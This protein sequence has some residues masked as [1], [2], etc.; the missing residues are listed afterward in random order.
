MAALPDIGKLDTTVHGPV[1]L[2]ILTALQMDRELDFTTL[3]KRLGVADGALG[4]HLG[5]LE[6][7]GYILSR[8]EFVGKRPR[9]SYRLARRGRAALVAYAAEMRRLL[10][11]IEGNGEWVDG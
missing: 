4:T 8:K 5:K 1:R 3:K 10:D 2:G 6:A 9:T 11:S 7:A